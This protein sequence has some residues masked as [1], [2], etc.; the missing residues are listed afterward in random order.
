MYAINHSYHNIYYVTLLIKLTGGG[1]K[2]FHRSSL[3][4]CTKYQRSHPE[5]VY[6]LNLLNTLKNLILVKIVKIN[7]YQDLLND[8][9]Y[10]L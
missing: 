10:L 5:K 6:N 8:V 7:K 1:V 3:R 2:L 9:S 4:C